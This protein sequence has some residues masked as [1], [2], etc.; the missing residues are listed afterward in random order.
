MTKQPIEQNHNDIHNDIIVGLG[1]LGDNALKALTHAQKV[2]RITHNLFITTTA[3]QKIVSLMREILQTNGYIDVNLLRNHTHLSRKYLIA[4]LEYLD[5][6]DDIVC[7][8]NKRTLKYAP[9]N[10]VYKDSSQ[11]STRQDSNQ[12][13]G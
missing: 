5:K 8:D 10:R 4:Y 2:V 11:D 13:K 1:S 7:K 12:P 3:L 6:F 9:Q